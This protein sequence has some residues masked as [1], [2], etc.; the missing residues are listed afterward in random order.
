MGKLYRRRHVPRRIG[1]LREARLWEGAAEVDAQFAAYFSAPV[2][3]W[4]R[5]LDPAPQ[6]VFSKG[7]DEYLDFILLDK[8]SLPG[9][10]TGWYDLGDGMRWK[11]SAPSVKIAALAAASE[12]F[13]IWRKQEPQ[14]TW[15]AFIH[16]CESLGGW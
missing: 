4:S 12:H 10:A 8:A 1:C 16:H 14:V 3:E 7:D 11:F 9:L 13:T 5:K 2:A 6:I 15:G